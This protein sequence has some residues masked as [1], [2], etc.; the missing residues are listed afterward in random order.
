M[1]Q[2]LKRSPPFGDEMQAMLQRLPTYFVTLHKCQPSSTSPPMMGMDG[3]SASV[4]N[5]AHHS[6]CIGL[7]QGTDNTDGG[8]SI[9]VNVKRSSLDSESDLNGEISLIVGDAKSNRIL[10]YKENV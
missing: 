3:T 8:S 4:G 5:D 6:R 10:F 7:Q 1:L 9:K 2:I